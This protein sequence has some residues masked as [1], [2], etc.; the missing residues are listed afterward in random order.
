MDVYGPRPIATIIF[1]SKFGV[2]L[3]SYIRFPDSADISLPQTSIVL[4]HFSGT[5]AREVRT[6]LLPQQA[7]IHCPKPEQSRPFATAN[8][9]HFRPK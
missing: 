6:C 5:L 2:Q 7:D 4:R 9:P 3:L 8:T 1:W